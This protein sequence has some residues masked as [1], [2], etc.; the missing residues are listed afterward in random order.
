MTNFE[1]KSFHIDVF[2]FNATQNFFVV[3]T[4]LSISTW[5]NKTKFDYSSSGSSIFHFLLLL[6]RMDNTL[7]YFYLLDQHGWC[8]QYGIWLLI[9]SSTSVHL[10]KSTWI[11]AFHRMKRTKVLQRIWN[12]RKRHSC[13]I[14]R[15]WYQCPIV[16]NHRVTCISVRWVSE[17]NKS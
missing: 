10:S 16:I 6:C 17:E 9:K 2:F 1:W 13:R 7:A 8:V 4:T 14:W 11:F 5:N 15:I 3:F 12:S